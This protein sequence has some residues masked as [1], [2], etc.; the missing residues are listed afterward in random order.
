MLPA[1]RSRFPRKEARLLDRKRREEGG[2]SGDLVPETQLLQWITQPSVPR[3][4]PPPQMPRTCAHPPGGAGP[5][6]A[7]SWLPPA[8][9]G[10]AGSIAALKPKRLHTG[11]AEPDS[12]DLRFFASCFLR[13]CPPQPARHLR[14][15]G[16]EVSGNSGWASGRRAGL[17]F[18]GCPEEVKLLC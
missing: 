10:A 2:S 7:H 12:P 5:P 9:P 14:R 11:A 3:G 6:G 18:A 4:P 8:L 17:R 15:L 13:S 16:A 1:D